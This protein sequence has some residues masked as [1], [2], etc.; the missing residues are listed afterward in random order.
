MMEKEAR[1]FVTCTGAL[2]IL[3]QALGKVQTL[4]DE[5]DVV[6]VVISQAEYSLCWFM[7]VMNKVLKIAYL[8]YI[9]V[10]ISQ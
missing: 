8:N 3:I 4:G 5:V 2:K 10:W 7:R 6:R 1:L 9:S